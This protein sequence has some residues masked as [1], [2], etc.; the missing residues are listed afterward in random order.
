MSMFQWKP[1]Y[2]VDHAEID[3]QHKRLFQLADDLGTAMTQ[4]KGKAA[5]GSTLASLID[6][7]KRHFATEEKLMQAHRYP[8]YAAHKKQHDDLTARVAGLQKEFMAGRA[9]MS[10][11][12]LQF[13]KD[14]LV[15]HIG[16]SDQ[17]IAAYLRTKAA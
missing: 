16:K 14:W 12:V 8:E 10:V 9:S 1:E 11:E 17:E 15:N 7:T 5:M 13:L 4:G 2:S 3:S 6:Y